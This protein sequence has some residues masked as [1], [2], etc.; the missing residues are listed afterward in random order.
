MSQNYVQQGEVLTVVAPAAVVSGDPVLIGA[1]IFGVATHDAAN[2]AA[3]ELAVEGVF[4][5]PADNNLVI[6]VGDRVFWVPASSW[7]NKTAA[8]QVCVGVAVSAKVLTGT[9]VNVK[10]ARNCNVPSGL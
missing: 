8:L 7:V 5:L 4:T 3:L 10:L 2:G 6:A 9:T 1:N